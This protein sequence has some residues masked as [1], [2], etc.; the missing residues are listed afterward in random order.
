MISD[1]KIVLSGT[2]GIFN[3][4]NTRTLDNQSLF[5]IGSTS[6]M[7]TATAVMMLLDQGKLDLDEP[8]T[9]FIREFKMADPRYKEITVRMLLNHSSGFLGSEEYIPRLKICAVWDRYI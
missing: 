9:T 8:V 3:K 1:G 5:G 6:K 4:D 2:S 7:F